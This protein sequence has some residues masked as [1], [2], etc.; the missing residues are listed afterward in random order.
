MGTARFILILSA[1]MYSALGV[2]CL[3]QPEMLLPHVGI[4]I[5]E[6]ITKS[7]IRTV[8]GGM[9]LGL[10]LFLWASVF[11]KGLLKSGL[12]L[13]FLLFLGLVG[14]RGFSYYYDGNPGQLGL[15]LGGIEVVGLLFSI[16]AMFKA[17]DATA[18]GAKA[19]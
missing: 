8:Y 4:I 17:G 19:A 5:K 6:T 13:N 11:A 12:L 9:E 2:M 18:S 1:L 3:W 15:I 14:G 7:D 10:A 16:I